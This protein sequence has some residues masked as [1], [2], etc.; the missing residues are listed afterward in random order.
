VALAK[1]LGAPER[2]GAPLEGDG[3]KA[4]RWIP[5]CQPARRNWPLHAGRSKLTGPLSGYGS[6]HKC[7]LC[8]SMFRDISSTQPTIIPTRGLLFFSE[9]LRSPIAKGMSAPRE[10]LLFFRRKPTARKFSQF[11]CSETAIGGH[12]FHGLPVPRPQ[13]CVRPMS[14]V[15]MTA[16]HNA[17]RGSG[18]CQKHAFKV[19]LIAGTTG[20]AL[21]VV[22]PLNRHI[23]PDV[24]HDLITPR[25][26]RVLCTAH[27]APSSP[28]PSWEAC[29]PVRWPRPLSDVAPAAR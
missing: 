21:L 11:C 25:A 23:T 14:A 16:G 2:P 4:G 7:N 9:V 10:H 27:L 19:V 24:R 29:W 15:H 18:P 22:R 26:R 20:S 5:Q 12:R 28:R 6:V 3:E 17:L 8:D 13:P 1:W